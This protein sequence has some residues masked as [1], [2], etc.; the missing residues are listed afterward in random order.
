MLLVLLSVKPA[1]SGQPMQNA[2]IW[3]GLGIGLIKLWDVALCQTKH[4]GAKLRCA[5]QE[6]Q[7]VQPY[8]DLSLRPFQWLDC[9][10]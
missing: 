7:L 4:H 2:Y 1:T 5:G 3:I 10:S 6:S 9:A 8:L